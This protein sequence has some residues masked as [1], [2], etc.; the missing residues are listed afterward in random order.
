MKITKI[1]F[2]TKNNQKR[3]EKVEEINLIEPDK[4]FPEIGKKAKLHKRKKRM[5]KV[6]NLEGPRF[7]LY[8]IG[9][10]KYFSEEKGR[11]R[12]ITEQVPETIGK[13]RHDKDTV[14]KLLEPV[15][16]NEMTIDYA[17]KQGRRLLNLST[18]PSTVWRWIERIDIDDQS[19]KEMENKT[20]EA[21]SGHASVDEVYDNGD[22]IIFITDPVN[23]LILS[24]EL[25]DGKP[26]LKNTEA[27]FKKIKGKNIEITSC[28]KDGSPLY[29]YSIQMVFMLVMLQTCI[30]HL[31]KNLIKGFMKWHR[32]IRT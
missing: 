25:L 9:Q 21:F 27:E 17:S 28:T 4:F 32:E 29:M 7:I 10:Y 30:F 6:A 26:T 8:H 2:I 31:M 15:I 14:I 5:I 16:R 13:M 24:Y 12:Y 19:Y 23:D 1:T 11:Y 20:V 18:V 22:G 3:P